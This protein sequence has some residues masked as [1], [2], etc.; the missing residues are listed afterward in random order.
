M[1]RLCIE[2]LKPK[3]IYELFKVQD[4]SVGALD[5]GLR[6]FNYEVTGIVGS[7]T[8]KRRWNM[9]WSGDLQGCIEL[10]VV[11]GF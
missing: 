3:S 11:R 8:G 1:W 2:A 4:V 5:C 7:P 10:R 6:V 9:T